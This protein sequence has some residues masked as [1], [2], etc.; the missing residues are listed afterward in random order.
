MT[1][2][3]ICDAEE[4]T[5]ERGVAAL[6]DGRQIAVFRTWDGQFYAVDNRDP[7]SGANIMSRGIVGTRGDRPTV[8]SPMHKQVFDLRTG[9]ALEDPDVLLGTW[10][11]RVVAG[12]LEVRQDRRRECDIR[13]G[14]GQDLSIP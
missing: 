6:L 7:F 8:A 4:L 9:Q 5:P 10:P 12:V 14:P 2:I 11:T 13:G 3:R 1:W